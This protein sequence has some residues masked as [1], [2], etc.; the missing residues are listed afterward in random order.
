MEDPQNP[1]E[2][3]MLPPMSEWGAAQRWTDSD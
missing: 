3:A 2:H 1:G